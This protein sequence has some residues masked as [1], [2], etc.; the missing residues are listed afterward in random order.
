MYITIRKGS[1][2]P[3]PE[4][5]LFKLF[6]FCLMFI[7]ERLDCHRILYCIAY[8]VLIVHSANF[9]LDQ[10]CLLCAHKGNY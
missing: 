4:H 8:L 9:Q 7:I 10:E 5:T 1:P 2:E 3:S 6:C